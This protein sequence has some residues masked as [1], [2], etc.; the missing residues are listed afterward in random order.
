MNE[1]QQAVGESRPRDFF[2]SQ[3]FCAHQ[4]LELRS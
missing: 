4:Q 3:I 1:N 2:P